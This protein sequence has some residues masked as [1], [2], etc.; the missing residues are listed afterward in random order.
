VCGSEECEARIK[1]E[2]MATIRVIP[3]SE[4]SNQKG[5]CVFCQKEARTMA[6]FARSY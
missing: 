3:L 6:V 2:T 1:E 5:R 4:E